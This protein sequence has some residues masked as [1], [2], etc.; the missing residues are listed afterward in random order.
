M[1][2]CCLRVQGPSL[3]KQRGAHAS[4]L[5]YMQN[6]AVLANYIPLRVEVI[7]QANQ[8]IAAELLVLIRLQEGSTEQV[9]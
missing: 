4:W 1:L 3:H 6:G 7:W 5:H 2:L 9:R 8:G